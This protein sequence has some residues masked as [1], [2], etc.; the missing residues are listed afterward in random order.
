[1]APERPQLVDQLVAGRIERL[2]DVLQAFAGDRFDPDQRPLDVRAAHGVEEVRI[3]GCLHRDLSEE[4]HVARQL[5][6]FSHQ[7]EPLRAQRLECL[8]LVRILAARGH[9]EVGQRD[10]IEV[11]IRQRDEPKPE[12]PEGDD[13]LDHGVRGA[14]A[15]FLSVRPPDGTERAVLGAAADGLDRRPH[16]AVGRQQV[17]PR[18]QELSGLDAAAF[19]DALL[20]AGEAIVDDAPPHPVAVSL[21]HRM[22]AAELVRLVRVERGVD[23]SVD[24]FCAGGVGGASD[25]VS[26]ERVTGMDADADDV[27]GADGGEVERL[28]RL[29][30][31]DRIAILGGCGGGQHVE[32]SRRDYADTEG[33][34]A[35]VDETDVH[36]GLDVILNPS[37]GGRKPPA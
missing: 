4:H 22:R 5:R 23:P 16:V 30:G 21:H 10:R 32:P 33:D 25:F 12:T 29:V 35:G 20:G 36:M 37:Q 31:Q 11:V 14:L 28:E 17:P 7:L 27:S 6:E 34:V 1:M 18:L 13:L 24:H 15:R 2:V 8:E 9:V 26:S 19:V 3:F